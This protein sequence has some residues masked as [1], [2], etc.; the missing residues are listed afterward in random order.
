MS[1]V[2]F[3]TICDTEGCED[4]SAEYTSFAICRVCGNDTCDKHAA[5]GSY[6]DH[7]DHWEC[8]CKGCAE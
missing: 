2:R 6:E 8:V 3:A 7:D 1:K 5:W 4:R